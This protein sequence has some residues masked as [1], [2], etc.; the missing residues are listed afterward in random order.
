M[1]KRGQV[2][3]LRRYDRMKENEP[4][5]YAKKLL[6]ARVNAEKRKIK[7]NK[8]CPD[9]GILLFPDSNRCHSCS[10]KRIKRRK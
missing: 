5:R 2:S 1:S 9:C 4:E 6:A 8:R 7:V 10:M 3:R